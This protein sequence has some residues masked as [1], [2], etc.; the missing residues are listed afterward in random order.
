FSTPTVWAAGVDYAIGASVYVGRRVYA[1]LVAHRS[2]NFSVDLA[3]GKWHLLADF[4]AVTQVDQSAIEAAQQAIA[5]ATAA[6]GSALA[7]AQTVAQSAAN[8]QAALNSANAAAASQTA[9]ANNAGSAS[10]SA[11]NA[12]ASALESASAATAVIAA[13]K[14]APNGLATL[15]IDGK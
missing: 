9:S 10:A 2:V 11:A 8:A 3:S 15:G 14:G 7:A 6:Q 5:A 13:Q 4:T 1:A 12:A